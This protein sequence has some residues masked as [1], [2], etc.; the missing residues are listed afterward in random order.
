MKNWRRTAASIVF[1][2][3]LPKIP[4]PVIRGPLRGSKFI[5]GALAGR[6][7]GATVYFNMIEPEQTS[8]FLSNL[9]EGQVLFD[10][11]ANVGY[12]TILGAHRVGSRGRVVA[13]EPAVRNLAYLYRHI[14]LNKIRN[15]SIISAACAET[16]SL[17]TFSACDNYAEGFLEANRLIEEVGEASLV[18]TVTLDMVVRQLGICP[19]VIKVDV[20]GAELSVLKGA[21]VTLQN[22]RPKIFLSTH[23]DHLRSACLE[24]LEERNYVFEVLSQDKCNP[25]E[26]LA[27]WRAI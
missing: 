26:F 10:V 24:Y 6:G 7:G 22:A 12:Y 15:V 1:G 25:T 5:L 21:P 16:L 17:A 11:G 3:L 20:E 8:A 4:Y 13:F 27:T 19:D 14:L 2:K 18:P 23:S 9:H